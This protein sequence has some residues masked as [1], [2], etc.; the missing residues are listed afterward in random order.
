MLGVHHEG[1][2]PQNY[3]SPPIVDLKRLGQWIH[4]ATVY[5]GKRGHVAHFLDGQKI[6]EDTLLERT[7]LQ[8]GQAE[9]GNW[10]VP[11]RDGA[12]AIRNFNGK[13]DE[14]ILLREPLSAVEIENLYL[15]GR[16]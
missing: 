8:F 14:L 10:G 16:P 2:E 7:V 12:M 11:V 13:M 15:V 3:T 1:V 4:L 5:D 9:I 6:H